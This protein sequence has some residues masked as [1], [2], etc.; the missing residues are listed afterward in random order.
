MTAVTTHA[1]AGQ[2]TSRTLHQGD[3][4]STAVAVAY[5][6]AGN[7]VSAT[8]PE[9]R[10]TTYTYTPD[11]QPLTKT[12]PSGT[13]TTHTYDPTS[14]LLSGIT[15]TAPGTA[16]P[17]HHLHPCTSRPARRR[18]GGHRHRRHRHDH[19]GYD[20]DGH[21]TSVSYPDGTST[22]ADYNDKGQMAT[23][24]DVTG[25]VTSY[26]HDAEEGTILSATQR[27]G[28]TVLASVTYE[29]DAMSRIATTT[30]G[31]GTVTTNAYTA[32]TSSP[33]R[34]R[35]TRPARC[36]RRTATPTTPTTTRPP[37]PTPTPAGAAP[38]HRRHLDHPLHL[39][40]LR[41]A[42]RLRR[43]RRT[44][45]Q[46]PAHRAGGDHHPLQRRLG[47]RRGGHHPTTRAGGIRPL[48]T[49]STSTNT[50][51]DS[52]RLT[53]QKTGAHHRHPDL[54]RRRTGA[55]LPRRRHHDLLD[56]RVT[57]DARRCATG[58]PRL[59][60]VARRHPA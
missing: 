42:D 15:V 18:T 44:A 48:T 58:P 23:T 14:G 24:T 59:H 52:G 43:L 13:V 55:H 9:G 50:I 40:R 60:A 51:D 11:G 1:L 22:A 35:R 39:R 53:A 41:P 49:K 46:R 10:T 34:P 12:S 21:R 17:G 33:P 16:D 29:Y 3:D 28:D 32:R 5:D 6:A 57:G 27:R 25:A 56:R 47:R 54:R 31:N 8:D 4:V 20:V 26:V 30:R 7:V 2:A 38:P 19:L 45:H 36:S 37:V